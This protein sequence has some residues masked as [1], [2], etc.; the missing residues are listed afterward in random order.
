[1]LPVWQIVSSHYNQTKSHHKFK[2]LHFL[3]FNTCPGFYLCLSLVVTMVMKSAV[4]D[5]DAG[6]GLGIPEKMKNSA[7]WV[8]ITHEFKSAC[9]GK[10]AVSDFV[11]GSYSLCAGMKATDM[12]P[13]LSLSLCSFFIYTE[14]NLG[15]LLHDKL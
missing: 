5:D 9:K 4:E 11:H 2:C 13:P 12:F 7:N 15:E 3:I 14:L 6:W 1:M 8:D 10:G